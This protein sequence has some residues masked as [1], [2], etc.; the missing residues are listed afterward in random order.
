MKWYVVPIIAK[1]RKS[2][3]WFDIDLTW[4]DGMI[5]CLPVFN[6]I[7]LAK[8]YTLEVMDDW[9]SLEIQT[10]ILPPNQPNNE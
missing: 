9:D 2:N 7:K 5:W 8:K 10:I 4:Y 1:S 3:I 6:S